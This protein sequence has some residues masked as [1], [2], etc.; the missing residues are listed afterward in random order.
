LLKA[1]RGSA[2]MRT[3]EV[4]E[5]IPVGR[6]E[7]CEVLFVA[8][9]TERELTASL[10]EVHAAIC[11]GGLRSGERVEPAAAR[12]LLRSNALAVV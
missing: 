4:I 6:C 1:V 2:V 9:P 12:L 11:P 5:T 7:R 3:N 8:R 10:L